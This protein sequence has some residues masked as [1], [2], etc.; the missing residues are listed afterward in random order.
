[1]VY[2]SQKQTLVLDYIIPELSFITPLNFTNN[3]AVFN[4][5][6]TAIALSY[7]LDAPIGQREPQYI[8]IIKLSTGEMVSRLDVSNLGSKY[9][10]FPDPDHIWY[11]FVQ[12]YD[13][14]EVRFTLIAGTDTY[15]GSKKVGFVWDTTT[16]DIREDNIYT[17]LNDTFEPIGEVIA[18]IET[19]DFSPNGLQVYV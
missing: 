16:G 13:A 3:D 11:Q 9:P 4:S 12:H 5:D 6:D 15:P 17:L 19:D 8:G 7:T 2:N 10:N 1:M 18:R 14:N